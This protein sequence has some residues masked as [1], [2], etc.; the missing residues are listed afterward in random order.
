MT[1]QRGMTLVELLVVLALAAIAFLAAGSFA[2]PWVQQQ[3][4]QSAIYA[5][6]THLQLARVEAITRNRACRFE[7]DTATRVVSVYDVMD[8]ADLS[9]DV[10]LHR[11]TLDTDIDFS[12]PEG[13]GAVTPSQIG[14]TTKFETVFRSDGV[15]TA[16]VGDVVLL[17]GL[18][19]NRISVFGV[20]GTQV[21]RWNNG[22]WH[23]GS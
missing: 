10:L 9:D 21:E 11:S 8:P 23:V 14:T 4:M 1:S 20:G 18:R 2:L 5:V 6:Q 16:G 13:G 12:R 17:G 3:T 19:Y 22:A 15:V 7:V